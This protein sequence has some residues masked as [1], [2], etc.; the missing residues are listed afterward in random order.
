[1]PARGATFQLAGSGAASQDQGIPADAE[2]GWP[3]RVL[4][5]NSAQ[6]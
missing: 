3:S 4:A 5:F 2:D 1:M 6:L